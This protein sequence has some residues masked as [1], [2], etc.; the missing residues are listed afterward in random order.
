MLFSTSVSVNTACKPLASNIEGKVALADRG[1]CSFVQKALNAQAA[2]AKALVVGNFYGD[3][4][5]VWMTAKRSEN[6]TSVSIPSVFINGVDHRWAA[7]WR[8]N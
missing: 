6:S 8:K 2:G 7:N 5:Y 4:R 3:N 1:N